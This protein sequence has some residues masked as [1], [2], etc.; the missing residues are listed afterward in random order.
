MPRASIIIAT[1]HRPRLLSRAVKSARA[2]GTD[3]EIIVVD[4]AS[5]DETAEVCKALSGI[6][7]VRVERNQG[8][9]GA[10]N[11]GLVASRGEYLSFLDDDDVRLENTLDRQI[12]ILEK[13][14]S[15]GLIYGQAMV[16]DS[17]GRAPRRSYPRDCP[18]GDLFW[19]LLSRNFIACGSVVFRRECLS[20][21]GLL[22][23]GIPGIDDWDLWIR[24]A[25]L[26]PIVAV[27]WPVMIWRRSTPASGQGTSQAEQLVS[28]SVRQFREH[29]MR[30]PRADEALPKTK[31][32]AW[33]SFS[34]NMGEHLIWE[35]ARAMRR[36]RIKQAFRNL[37]GLSMLHP[38]TIIR[39][40]NQRALRIP[41][42]GFPE[43]LVCA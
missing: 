2:S 12:E 18:Q 36:G 17:N 31:Q 8:V 9:A 42:K 20:R 33:R 43:P 5:S 16:Q 37:S 10:R 23:D 35:S 26:Y 41:R 3:V 25:E 34:D 1:H 39:I 38:L 21:V 32:A 19:K 27:D 13:D 7:Y 14:L 29:W 6:K 24:I 22:D 40:A 11:I 15:A 4:D 30:L 28:L